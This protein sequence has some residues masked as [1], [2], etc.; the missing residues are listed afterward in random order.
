[1]LAPGAVAGIFVISPIKSGLSEPEDILHASFEPKYIL[2][3]KRGKE[4]GFH[5]VFVVLM[6]QWKE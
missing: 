3:L 2:P 5:Y 6:K 1:M 4:V